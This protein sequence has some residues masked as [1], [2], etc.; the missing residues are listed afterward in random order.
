MTTL[1]NSFEYLDNFLD[2]GF[3][4]VN[5]VVDNK[6]YSIRKD[7]ENSFLNFTMPYL[8]KLQDLMGKVTS[9]IN[10]VKGMAD[11]IKNELQKI[12]DKV[13]KMIN[14]LP[15]KGWAKDVKSWL[16]LIDD[17]GVQDFLIRE[18]SIGNLV[19]CSN[20]D[21]LQDI[22]D[23]YD[24][25]QFVIEGL[26]MGLSLDWANRTC[27]DFSRE[28]EERMSNKELIEG[29][30]PYAG[31]EID[32][33]SVFQDFAGLFNGYYNNRSSTDS[34]NK[35][36]PKSKGWF[37][38]NLKN[39]SVS[40]ILDEI[41]IDLDREYKDEYMDILTELAPDFKGNTLR[42]TTPY[43]DVELKTLELR[44]RLSKVDPYKREDIIKES[45]KLNSADAFGSYLKNLGEIDFSKVPRHSL[46]NEQKGI[47]DKIA[48]LQG[49]TNNVE[50]RSR[51]H[52]YNTFT[53]FDFSPIREFFTEEEIEV[54]AKVPVPDM[55]HRYNNLSVTTEYFITGRK[56]AVTK[57][58][59]IH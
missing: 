47:M 8:N 20:L 9:T 5:H 55:S 59:T 31:I 35:P 16:S 45:N 54:M 14:D 22:L 28:Q 58:P 32:N 4:E 42:N 3:K 15:F 7:L 52:G 25:D 29:M 18:L 19:L 49:L 34:S 41:S 46:T 53:N 12:F 43:T 30:I 11:K 10:K 6:V 38:D 40:D 36:L 48:M 1:V 56:R 24:V 51:K 33:S 2:V 27:K 39:K 26:F 23:G 57:K 50:F 37:E 17:V 21:T 13:M 44:G